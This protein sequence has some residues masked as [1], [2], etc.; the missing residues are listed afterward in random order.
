MVRE[1]P[2]WTPIGIYTQ[3]DS[4]F[5]FLRALFLMSESQL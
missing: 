4:L 2:F 3:N 1:G 5:I